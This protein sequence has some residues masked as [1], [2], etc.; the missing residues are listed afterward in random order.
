MG[1]HRPIF[2]QELNPTILHGSTLILELDLVGLKSLLQRPNDR[3]KVLILNRVRG[4]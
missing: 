1:L 2:C 3:V 4:F